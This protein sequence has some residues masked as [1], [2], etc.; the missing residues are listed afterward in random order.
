MA[1]PRKKAV[2]TEVKVLIT[3][4][5]VAATVGGW[6]ALSQVS[7]HAAP[8]LASAQVQQTQAVSANGSTSSVLATSA[9]APAPIT[10]TRS[11]R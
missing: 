1:E 9:S 8:T 2:S 7:T 5:A 4:L 11:S 10:F 3:T 6:G